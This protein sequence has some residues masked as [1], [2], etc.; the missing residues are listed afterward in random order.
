MWFLQPLRIQT[1]GFCS[2]DQE[3]IYPPQGNDIGDV[4]DGDVDSNDGKKFLEDFGGVSLIPVLY[5]YAGEREHSN[6]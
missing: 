3:Y 2:M 5:V 4:C 6:R 1:D